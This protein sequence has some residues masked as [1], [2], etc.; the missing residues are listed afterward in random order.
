MSK[1]MENQTSQDN[2]TMK[3]VMLVVVMLIGLAFGLMVVVSIV[4]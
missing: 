1:K 4:T 2:K 3:Q